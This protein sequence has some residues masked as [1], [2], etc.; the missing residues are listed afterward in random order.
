MS[1]EKILVA[2]SGGVDSAVTTLML[3]RQGYDV[4]T[5]YLDFLDEDLSKADN[6]RNIASYLNIPFHVVRGHHE[7]SEKVLNYF[8]KEY[9]AGR[10]PNPCAL[11]NRVFKF[12]QMIC[13]ANE[14]NINLIATGHYARIEKQDGQS[15][16]LRGTDSKR[17]QSYFLFNLTQEQLSRTLFPIGHLSK[18]KI[19]DIARE[20]G[21][22]C[23]KTP[24]SQDICFL[25]KD[26]SY[27][28]FINRHCDSTSYQPGDIRDV[29]G[30]LIGTHKGLPFYTVG[31]RR[32]LYLDRG[33]PWFVV[34]LEPEN[35]TLVVG[36][37]G[38]LFSRG[39]LCLRPNWITSQPAFPFHAKCMIRYRQKAFDCDVYDDAGEYL[40]VEFTEPQAS[41]TPGQAI[42]F[43]QE[44]VV[45][46]GA[47][48]K[49]H[50]K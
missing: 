46:G 33:G 40:R 16:L 29:S 34:K 4:E 43:F 27:Q 24:D 5:C 38:D 36:K 7:F 39:L 42:V 18:D 21:L 22:P 48:I 31:Q 20:N 32:G 19:R 25:A 26:D 15:Y 9:L 13:K 30:N 3:L 44:D 8:F 14:L 45:F 49:N 35:N 12:S 17:D 50:I 23:A 1:K 28:S 11:C 47:W 6:A 41:V 10:T 37:H 2:L